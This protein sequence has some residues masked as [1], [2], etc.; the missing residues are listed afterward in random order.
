M[1]KEQQLIVLIG[2]AELGPAAASQVLWAVPKLLT[3]FR[4]QADYAP[5][6]SILFG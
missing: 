2:E 6:I 5:D 3:C 1:P 4:I